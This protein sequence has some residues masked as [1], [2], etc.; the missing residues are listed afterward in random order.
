MESGEL[1]QVLADAIDVM[2]EFANN[3]CYSTRAAIKSV[4]D[5]NTAKLYKIKRYFGVK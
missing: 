4:S 1:K 3:P 2:K 5:I